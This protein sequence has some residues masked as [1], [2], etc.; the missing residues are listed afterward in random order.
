MH[1]M[2][3]STTRGVDDLHTFMLEGGWF[4]ELISSYS[5]CKPMDREQLQSAFDD[6]YGAIALP[7]P[8][9]LVFESPAACMQVMQKDIVN[10]EYDTGAAEQGGIQFGR[11]LAQ[12]IHHQFW[13]PLLDQLTG[14]LGERAWVG[15]RGESSVRDLFDM[16]FWRPDRLLIDGLRKQLT[17]KLQEQFDDRSL[18][19]ARIVLRASDMCWISSGSL[20]NWVGG[21]LDL[22]TSHNLRI[23][24]RI[25][26]QCHWWYPFENVVVASERPVDVDWDRPH[27]LHCKDGPSVEF[28]DGFKLFSWHGCNVPPHWITDRSI[29]QPEE[30]LQQESMEVRVAGASI[31]G[32]ERMSRVLDG[33]VI[34]DSGAEEIGQL[35]ELRFPEPARFLKA[36]C[37]DEGTIIEPVPHVSDLDGLPINTA[38]AAQAWLSNCAQAEYSPVP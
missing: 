23:I 37:P 28:A 38:H 5:G 25:R 15:Y 33:H 14:Q 21:L 11:P 3:V 22:Q 16:D 27:R 9:L 6:L 18:A 1:D 10:P 32:W 13:L 8:K 29:L 19:D 20:A 35:V 4:G 17:D 34:D 7:A 24:D 12:Q 26:R 2:E 31:V 30:V 36:I